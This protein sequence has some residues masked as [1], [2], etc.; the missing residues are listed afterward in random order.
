MSCSEP[1][2]R[3]HNYKWIHVHLK[4]KGVMLITNIM[5]TH[6]GREL[7]TYAC[8]LHKC[9]Q[10]VFSI[11]VGAKIY[12]HTITNQLTS[13]RYLTQGVMLIT[14]I[15]NTHNG[16]RLYT[17]TCILHKCGWPIFNIH[18]GAKI[19]VHSITNQLTSMSYLTQ[20]NDFLIITCIMCT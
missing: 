3:A 4:N 9:G 14:N 13:I 2:M 17:Y 16:R 1:Y 10:P 12:V 18:V 20:V 6:D 7:Y 11:H 5:N 15:M 8:I 19:Y